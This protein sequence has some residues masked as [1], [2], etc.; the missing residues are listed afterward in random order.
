MSVLPIRVYLMNAHRRLLMLIHLGRPSRTRRE[1]ETRRRE[2]WTTAQAIPAITAKVL[3]RLLPTVA[4]LLP[5]YEPI[6][7]ALMIGSI[8]LAG[9]VSPGLNSDK[10]DGIQS[11]EDAA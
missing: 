4:C 6:V 10:C 1:L 7:I 9:R 3:E 5:I 8:M 11:E 2:S